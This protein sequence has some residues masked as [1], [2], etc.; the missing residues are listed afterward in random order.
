[1]FGGVARCFLASLH[2]AAQWSQ[3]SWQTTPSTTNR[4]IGLSRSQP[5]LPSLHRK[6]RRARLHPRLLLLP[7]PP[8]HLRSLRLFYRFRSTTISLG[9][10]ESASAPRFW[11]PW[12]IASSLTW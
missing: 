10:T 7:S 11:M 4:P 6:R 1:M 12:K 2:L 9:G 3:G 8:H 5:A